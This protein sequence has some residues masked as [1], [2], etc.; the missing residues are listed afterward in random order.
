MKFWIREMGWER[1]KRVIMNLLGVILK[2]VCDLNSY[3]AV[4]KNMP[5]PSFFYPPF[6]LHV[7]KNRTF[8]IFTDFYLFVK[9]C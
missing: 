9:K 2:L 7:K 6:L 4:N 8:V 3:R 1:G 5:Y